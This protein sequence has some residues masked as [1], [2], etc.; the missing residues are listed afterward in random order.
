MSEAVVIS[1]HNVSKTFVL[2]HERITSVK[3]LFTGMAQKRGHRTKGKDIQSALNEIKFEV[4]RGEFFGIVGRNGSGKSTLLKILAGIYQPSEGTVTTVG[5][6]VPFIEL[7][8]GFNPELTGRENVYL[9]GAMLGFS[10]KEI[11]AMYGE[12]VAF[13]ELERFMDQKL[14]N[15]SSGMQVRL[16]FSMAIRAKA[17]ILLIDEVLAVGDA[18]FQRKCF[19]YFKRLKR[20]KKTVVFVSH[21][22]NAVREYCDRAIMIEKSKIIATGTAEKIAT[23]YSRMFIEQ[24]HEDNEKKDEDTRWGTK[25]VCYTDVK[26]IVNEK[27]ISIELMAVANEN[28]EDANFGF[29]IKDVGGQSLFGTNSQIKRTSIESFVKDSSIKLTWSLPNILKDGDYFLNLAVV[30]KN[31]EVWDWWDEAGEFTV[32]KEERPPYLVSPE[33]NLTVELQ[34][35]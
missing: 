25:A 2:P 32:Y 13:A 17:D 15:Y 11:E 18:D 28:V 16:A 14:K 34:K 7:G 8:V 5:K 33:I 10:R 26:I 30:N 27:N 4:R 19:D 22:M 6:L 3:S 24:A 12:I 23:T 20:N 21:D 9:N 31:G 35:G 1:V 29:S